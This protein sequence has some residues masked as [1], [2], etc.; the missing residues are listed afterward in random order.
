[1]AGDSDVSQAFDRLNEETVFAE[2]Y[3][4]VEAGNIR[5]GLRAQALVKSD[6]DSTKAKIEYMKLRVQSL[7]DE[8]ILH[9]AEER[10]LAKESAAE[11]R[12]LAKES[13]AQKKARKAR[14][15]KLQRLALDAFVKLRG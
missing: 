4:E 11:E 3:R 5:E 15:K 10:E 12:E 13:A 2:V 9:A 1:M 14:E 7:K 8:L 6:G